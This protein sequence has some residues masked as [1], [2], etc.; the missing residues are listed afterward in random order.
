MGGSQVEE[1]A[2]TTGLGR[3]SV[4]TEYRMYLPRQW[5]SQST[6]QSST[7]ATIGAFQKSCRRGQGLCP[8]I[9]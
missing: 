2:G 5:Q 7:I 6:A 3:S 4:K 1:H 9:L 8:S